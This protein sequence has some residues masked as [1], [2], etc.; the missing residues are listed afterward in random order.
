VAESVLKK[1]VVYKGTEN[2]LDGKYNVK[3]V[4]IKTARE[5][6]LE[7]GLSVYLKAI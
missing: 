1:G 5:K 3:Y 6:R 4:P 7:Y 2:I